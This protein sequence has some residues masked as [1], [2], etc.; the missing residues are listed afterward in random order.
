MTT[1]D[2]ANMLEAIESTTAEGNRKQLN[3]L[4]REL[5]NQRIACFK[6]AMAAGG[7]QKLAQAIL[8]ILILE[9]D[10]EEEESIEL[11]ELAY[12]ACSYKISEPVEYKTRVLLLHYFYDYFTDTVVTIFLDKY[13]ESDLLQ[14][15]TLA[16]ESL[17]RMQ[18][19][20]LYAIE[21][22]DAQFVNQDQQLIDAGNGLNISPDLSQEEMLETTTMHKVVFAYLVHKY[23]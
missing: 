8:K 19:H 3:Q 9:L 17:E 12:M 14:A 1:I 6:E 23:N 21:A 2:I 4:L 16:V 22:I 13:R 5:K 11:A 20:D 18:L 7:G 15:R 10:E